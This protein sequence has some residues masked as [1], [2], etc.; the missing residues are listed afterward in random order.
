M[1]I[2]DCLERSYMMPKSMCVVLQCIE[3]RGC[4]VTEFVSK[5]TSTFSETWKPLFVLFIYEL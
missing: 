5:S 1:L 2:K 3:K 4:L